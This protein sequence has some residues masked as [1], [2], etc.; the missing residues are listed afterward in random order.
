V[1]PSRSITLKACEKTMRYLTQCTALVLLIVLWSVGLSGCGSSSSLPNYPLGGTVNGLHAGNSVVL[2][3][4]GGDNLTV[5]QSGPFTFAN[6]FAPGSSYA[7]TVLTQPAGQTCVVAD[8]SGEMP[9]AVSVLGAPGAHGVNDIVVN[10]SASGGPFS[11]SGTVAGLLPG[12]AVVLQDNGV[13]NTT[14]SANGGFAFSVPL[15]SGTAYAVSILT[16]PPG[17]SCAISNGSGAAI[18]ANVAN[19]AVA[20]SDNNFTIAAVV[21]GLLANGSLVLQ[22]NGANN[23][24]ASANGKATFNTPIPSGSSYAV[25]VLTQPVGE[26][27][28][29]AN[30]TGT[31]TSANISNVAVACSPSTFTIGGTVSGLTAT[32][33]LQ[34]DAA[35]NLSITANGSFVFT[36]PLASGSS[37]AVTVLTQPAGQT[38]AVSNGTGSV[39][40]ANVTDVT[41]TC[42]TGAATAGLWTWFGG[43]NTF[44]A[45]GVYGTQGVAAP[46]NQPGAR[47]SAITWTDSAGNLWLFGGYGNGDTGDDIGPLNDLWRFSPST[48]LWT[49]MSGSNTE[50]AA[51]VY[52]S[53]GTAAAGNVPGARYSAVSWI[54]GTGNLW[55]FGGYALGGNDLN[56]LWRYSPST[57]LWT[58]MSGSNVPRAAGAYGTEGV[59]AAGNVPGARLSSV[60]WTDHEGNFWLFGGNDFTGPS[61]LND[62]WRYSPSTG[63]WTWMSGSNTPGAAGVYGTQGIAAAGN[64]PGERDYAVSWTDSSGNL[65][66]F[67]GNDSDSVTGQT[68]LNDLWRYSPST[69]LWTWIGGSNTG[70]AGGVYG[71]QLL[72]AAGNFPGS[73]FYA[74]S[75]TDPS[76][77]FWLFGGEGNDSTDSVGGLNDLWRYN[78]TTGL[79]TWMSGSNTLGGVGVYGTEGIAAAGNVPGNRARST[80]WSDNTGNLWL[81]GGITVPGGDLNDLWEYVPP[82]L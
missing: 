13:N 46:G 43:S 80:T 38:C 42:A 34:D 6:E 47:D 19:V 22:L 67:G 3:N 2:Q 48:G 68:E 17:Q 36:T 61:F 45:V 23:L 75:W 74:V 56:D 5:A 64:V 81:F 8:G 51:G 41:V 55:L 11:V 4:N 82:G 53:L 28:T 37:Y 44:Y 21:S 10:C 73:R 72:A 60:S 26:S 65:W 40:S 58:W 59:A 77:N 18:M 69:G 70:G 35:D 57:G 15:A 7:V 14:I 62:L 52:G 29:V 78:P 54:D 49:W 33:V 25:T 20:C 30:G 76:G 63:L 79:W 66:L 50:G 31:V 9:G 71:T 1:E 24:T 16:Q 39:A 12:N 27:C 32:V